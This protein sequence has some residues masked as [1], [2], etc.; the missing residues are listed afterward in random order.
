[1]IS[2]SI[3]LEQI[4]EGFDDMKTGSPRAAVIMFDA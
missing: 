2:A 4:N 3:K 1:M